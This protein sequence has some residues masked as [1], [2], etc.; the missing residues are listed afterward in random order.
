MCLSSHISKPV[1]KE[2][3]TNWLYTE[4]C[5]LNYTVDWSNHKEDRSNQSGQVGPQS[6]QGKPQS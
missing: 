3:G 4:F 2:T 6:G 1:K 5:I